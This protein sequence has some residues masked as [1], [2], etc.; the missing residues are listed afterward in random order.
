[1]KKTLIVSRFNE[2]LDWLK[3][4]RGWNTIIYN[5]GE[6]L[7]D[8]ESIQLP[9]VGRESH[10][11]LTHIINNYNRLSETIA[12][13]QGNPFDHNPT[14]VECLNSYSPAPGFHYFLEGASNTCNIE[15]PD[16]PGLPIQKFCSEHSI[17]C[18][19]IIK[20][21]A[22]G[23]FIVSSCSIK[24]RPKS[25]YEQIIETLKNDVNPINGFVIERL[26]RYIFNN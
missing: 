8:V 26:W 19:N 14:A 22:G 5:K 17:R 10:T 7:I 16:H 12:F 9:N 21:A 11:Y 18:D 4:I 6:K 15:Q 25:F 13:V 2:N 1:M 3:L 23:Q 20:F 24:K